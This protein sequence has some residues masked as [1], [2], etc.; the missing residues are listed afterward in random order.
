[1]TKEYTNEGGLFAAEENNDAS[2]TRG[3]FVANAEDAPLVHPGASS[4][5]IVLDIDAT[6]FRVSG[7]EWQNPSGTVKPPANT[8]P[9]P[10]RDLVIAEKGATEADAGGYASITGD[11]ISAHTWQQMRV[12]D[13]DDPNTPR[14]DEEGQPLHPVEELPRVAPPDGTG[15][16]DIGPVLAMVFVPPG[17]GDSTD[18]GQEYITDLTKEGVSFED[19]LRTGDALA[20]VERANR[21]LDLHAEN[22]TRL[23]ARTWADLKREGSANVIHTTVD[24]G[25]SE[26]ATFYIPAGH[27]IRT[28]WLGI[29]VGDGDEGTGD[30]TFQHRNAD[31]T[32]EN[33]IKPVDEQFATSADGESPLALN[34]SDGQLWRFRIRNT[35]SVAR[36]IT[37]Q[38]HQTI[39]ETDP[40]FGYVDE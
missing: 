21:E 20:E 7:G 17:A 16:R 22:A 15:L 37:A 9:Y 30:M 26:Y 5:E 33:R 14:L 27:S 38:Y 1:M 2:A 29:V 25:A 39:F 35:G 36:N 13:P 3:T 31:G 19:V 28:W 8:S 34:N 24:A 4:S 23:D 10:R 12:D 40:D 18:I 6:T 32:W 11:P